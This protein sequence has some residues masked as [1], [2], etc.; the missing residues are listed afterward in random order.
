MAN[1][2]DGDGRETVMLDPKERFERLKAASL[3]LRES[4][5]PAL[6]FYLAEE[7]DRVIA[8]FEP[9]R[10]PNGRE[11]TRQE[12]ELEW[13][14][15]RRFLRQID[16][17]VSDLEAFSS[18]ARESFEKDWTSRNAQG[19]RERIEEWLLEDRFHGKTNRLKNYALNLATV[20][21]NDD[22]FEA[23]KNRIVDAIVGDKEA[24]FTLSEYSSALDDYGFSDSE[25]A[26]S[27]CD[28]MIDFLR[29]RLMNAPEEAHEPE[30]SHEPETSP[31]SESVSVHE[32]ATPESVH[33]AQPT[34]P[35]EMEPN[36]EE[37]ES[38]GESEC[39]ADDESSRGDDGYYPVDEAL[40]RAAQEANSFREYS[41]GSATR[42]YR[43]AVD[44]AR[45]VAARQKEKVDERYHEKIDRIL[46]SYERRL[47][48]W[49]DR[50]HRNAASCPSIMIA[51]AGNFP[52][53]KHEKKVRRTGELLREHEKITELMRA[54]QSVGLGG[55]SSDD[56]DA[57]ERLEAKL[58]TLKERHEEMKR[59]N[60][61]RR[62]HGS[63]DGYDGPLQDKICYD[64]PEFYQYFNLPNSLAEIHRVDQ[65]IKFLKRQAEMEY[66][67]GWNFDGGVVKAN[68]EDNRLQIFFD[69]IPSEQTRAELRQRGF[70]WSPR[71]R[72]WQRMLTPDAIYAAKQLGFIPKDWTMGNASQN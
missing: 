53:K 22:D 23:K 24:A 47:A 13:R 61:Y 5:P 29:D 16:G 17:H 64:G 15:V 59:A 60:K 9:P 70:R 63:W 45:E 14:N 21:M 25:E 19:R 54:L 43:A 40:A 57:I 38:S 32:Q 39:D 66:G 33:L 30:E 6:D 31:S 7:M 20:T 37:D 12:Q 35:P 26:K 71:N 36:D 46:D 44:S 11:P 4:E 10:D 49:Y 51:G 34:A 2:E 1:L 41:P 48:S 56:A 3:Y 8:L 55:I 50:Y 65:R 68:K 27:F 18:Y 58:A 72:A 52:R 69:S 42:E 28:A 67:G 62:E